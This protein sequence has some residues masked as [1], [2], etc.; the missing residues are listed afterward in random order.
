MRGEKQTAY[1]SDILLA[2]YPE[3]AKEFYVAAA[4][5]RSALSL[6]ETCGSVISGHYTGK[7]DVELCGALARNI[8]R[9]INLAGQIVK[10]HFPDDQTKLND[11][12]RLSERFK[13]LP[14]Y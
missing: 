7:G 8:E 10:Q 1:R 13:R 2:V 9:E 14:K 6:Y 3:Q 4:F 12:S 5:A 11:L